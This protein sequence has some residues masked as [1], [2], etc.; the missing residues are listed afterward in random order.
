MVM[1]LLKLKKKLK[2]LKGYNMTKE[3]KIG[4]KVKVK[5]KNTN[6]IVDGIV[7][8]SSEKKIEGLIEVTLEDKEGVKILYRYKPDEILS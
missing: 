2:K 4:Q 6:K 7:S 8:D 1:K 5:D 3:L